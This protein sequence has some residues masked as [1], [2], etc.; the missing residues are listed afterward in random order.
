[1]DKIIDAI[2][3][4]SD[5]AVLVI[6]LLI[7]FAGYKL[8]KLCLCMGG[9]C[10]GMVIVRRLIAYVGVTDDELSRILTYVAA[11]LIG[12][13]LA[14]IAFKFLKAGAFLL[15]AFAAYMIAS[16]FSLSITAVAL[17]TLIC[18]VAAIVFFRTAVIIA[19]AVAGG[20]LAGSA[21]VGFFPML[22]KIPYPSVVLGLVLTVV[23]MSAQF[24]M[25]R[26]KRH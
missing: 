3:S 22:E 14:G 1:M 5:V 11:I 15:S 21:L 26:R 19:S 10:V 6:A 17:I 12:V 4:L 20:M 7:C 23:G 13:A 25:K 9:F 24:S 16:S 2:N 18:G 8:S